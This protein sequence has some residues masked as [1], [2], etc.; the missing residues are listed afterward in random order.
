MIERTLD[1]KVH[2]KAVACFKMP[3]KR[4]SGKL[5]IR[6]SQMGTFYFSPS[7]P[8]RLPFL[9]FPFNGCR[10]WFGP[11]KWTVH[12]GEKPFRNRKHIAL[13]PNAADDRVARHV[14]ALVIL[15]VE[16]DLQRVR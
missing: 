14:T 5:Q 4:K 10:F 1:L 15:A 8:E 2:G 12:R 13:N 9:E 3:G 6:K 7:E 16:A 11:S